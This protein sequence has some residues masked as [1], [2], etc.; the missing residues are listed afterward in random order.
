MSMFLP[1]TPLR[2]IGG[3]SLHIDTYRQTGLA[4]QAMWS[5]GVMA[6]APKTCLYQFTIDF[7]IDQML[8]R[9]HLGTGC[10]FR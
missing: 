4:M 3:E 9:Y 2:P 8:W 10:F 7:G 1:S 6:A 5:V